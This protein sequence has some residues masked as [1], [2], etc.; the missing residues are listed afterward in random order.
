MAGGFGSRMGN[1]TKNKPKA[2]LEVNGLPMIEH[3]IQQFAASGVKKIYISTFYL[4]DKIIDLAFGGTL[5]VEISYLEEEE[6]LGTAGAL[7][8]LDPK[9][10]NNVLI[11][12]CDVMT[13][14]NHKSLGFIKSASRLLLWQSKN[15]LLHP[16]GVVEFENIFYEN[17]RKAHV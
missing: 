15:T 9:S 4:K 12:N 1:L 16:F 14:L 7:R 10:F 5:N 13:E 6:P 17:N 3:I 8:L 11:S 2:L